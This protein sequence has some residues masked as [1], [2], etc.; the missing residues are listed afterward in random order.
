MGDLIPSSAPGAQTYNHAALPDPG[1]V[2]WGVSINPLP[3]A[4]TLQSQACL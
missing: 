1:R 4:V 2:G 3:P